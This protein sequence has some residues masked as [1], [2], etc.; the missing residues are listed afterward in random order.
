MSGACGRC[1]W[2]TLEIVAEVLCR[3]IHG[4]EFSAES[5]VVGFCGGQQVG[6]EAERQLLP[7]WSR[8]VESRSH[9]SRRG[10]SRE[11]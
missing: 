4:E 9:S 3:K 7:I 6:E 2:C 10:A 11:E 1:R 8:L 5:T